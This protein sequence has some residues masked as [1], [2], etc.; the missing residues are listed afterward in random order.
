LFPPAN[1]PVRSEVTDDERYT[2]A[3]LA[4]AARIPVVED[5]L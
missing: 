3:A 4:V 1:W 2:G 5:L